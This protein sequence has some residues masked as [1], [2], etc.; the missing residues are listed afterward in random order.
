MGLGIRTKLLVMQIVRLLILLIKLKEMECIRNNS[1][2]HINH[3]RRCA[4]V[5]VYQ[6]L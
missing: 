4:G 6:F 5:L 1:V 2:F 3:V